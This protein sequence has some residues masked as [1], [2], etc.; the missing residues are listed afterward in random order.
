MGAQPKASMCLACKDC[1]SDCS[2]KDFANMQTIKVYPD[3]VRAVKCDD[4]ERPES[5][6][7]GPNV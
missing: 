7:G 4:F 5:S 3:G 6:E 2:G 1:G